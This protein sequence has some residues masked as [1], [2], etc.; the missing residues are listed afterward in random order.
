MRKLT[1]FSFLFVLVSCSPT[2]LTVR[3]EDGKYD[4]EQGMTIA[5]TKKGEK[6]Q[7]DEACRSICKD[8]DQQLERA[9][10]WVDSIRTHEMV[11]RY[12]YEF[13]FDTIPNVEFKSR[14]KYERKTHFYRVLSIEK[15]PWYVYKIPTRTEYKTVSYDSL[16]YITYSYKNKCYRGSPF[17]AIFANPNRIRKVNME[18]AETEVTFK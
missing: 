2:K 13:R 5:V 18:G 15:R 12:D 3:N 17:K 1:F 4:I 9:R 10:W 16:M 14:S 11:L 6:Y 7:F 8:C